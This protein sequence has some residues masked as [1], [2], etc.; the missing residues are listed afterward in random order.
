MAEALPFQLS[1]QGAGPLDTRELPGVAVKDLSAHIASDP[2]A[3]TGQ[4]LRV[5]GRLYLVTDPDAG[6]W[7][8]YDGPRRLSD[9]INEYELKEWILN[10]A[11]VFEGEHLWLE[12]TNEEYVVISTTEGTWRRLSTIREVPSSIDETELQSWLS[13]TPDSVYPGELVW[14]AGQRSF[15]YVTDPDTGAWQRVSARLVLDTSEVNLSQAI[16]SNAALQRGAIV[17]LTST[18]AAYLVVDGTDGLWRR[19]AGRAIVRNVSESG[20]TA[21]I[22]S[23]T[24]TYQ[25]GQ[26][27]FLV[28]EEALYTVLDPG[29]GRWRRIA[30][31]T[32][33][34]VVRVSTDFTVSVEDEERL[35]VI[36]TFL[37][38]TGGYGTPRTVTLPTGAPLGWSVRFQVD[39]YMALRFDDTNVTLRGGTDVLEEGRCVHVTCTDTDTFRVEAAEEPFVQSSTTSLAFDR[40]FQLEGPVPQIASLYLDNR[41]SAT[42]PTI[43]HTN[44]G[45]ATREGSVVIAADDGTHLFRVTT[46]VGMPVTL[47]H[48]FQ[49]NVVVTYDTDGRRIVMLDPT[50]LPD[51]APTVTRTAP[52]ATSATTLYPLCADWVDATTYVLLLEDPDTPRL[53]EV[54]VNVATGSIISERTT[55]DV[56]NVDGAFYRMPR[57]HVYDRTNDRV[58]LISDAAAFVVDPSDWLSPITTIRLEYVANE[59]D[60]WNGVMANGLIYVGESGR[61]LSAMQATLPGGGVAGRLAVIDPNT[62]KLV[63]HLNGV[64]MQVGDELAVVPKRNWIVGAPYAGTL[65][66][67]S[68]EQQSVPYRFDTSMEGPGAALHLAD[69]GKVLFITDTDYAFYDY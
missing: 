41:Y 12:A 29:N 45:A 38:D 49:E 37:D 43:W 52:L 62:M 44:A 30:E 6:S 11:Q 69:Q 19:L 46:D 10:D 23:T 25:A 54:R 47:T 4:T 66:V 67:A 50:T 64:Y 31:P 57:R 28:D 18:K 61:N 35:F 58:Y 15:Y 8:R 26:D 65:E 40:G 14:S 68:L 21:H 33:S 63:A 7:R 51:S 9:T 48:M 17:W 13:R 1:Y 36:D 60:F 42:E 3:F 16:Q 34:R 20:L 2:T 5:A 53:V 22:T 59:P 24:Y 55:S 39:S 27:I 32:A 56:L